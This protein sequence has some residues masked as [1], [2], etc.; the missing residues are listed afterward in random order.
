[1]GGVTDPGCNALLD[2]PLTFDLPLPLFVDPGFE[3]EV[4]LEIEPEPVVSFVAFG[5]SLCMVGVV[6]AASVFIF[7][8]SV[9][10]VVVAFFAKAI[11]VFTLN[12][13]KIQLS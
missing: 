8:V 2:T 7:P 10:V 6:V 12:D 9:A 5:V 13:S 11:L 3:V 4:E 1:L